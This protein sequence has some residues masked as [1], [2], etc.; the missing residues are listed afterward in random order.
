MI[1]SGWVAGENYLPLDVLRPWGSATGLPVV[2]FIHGGGFLVGSK[3]VP[4]Q[5]GATF[6]RLGVVYVAMNCRMAID[7]LLPIPG[8]STK[9]GLRDL[10]AGL[11]RVQREI[12]GFGGDPHTV[13]VFSESAGG[14]A[15]AGLIASPLAEGLSRAPSCRAATAA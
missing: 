11:H 9:L 7:G 10:I 2:V 5:E 15:I 14:L 13:T 3:N 8:V 4:V 6:A 12:A 1:G